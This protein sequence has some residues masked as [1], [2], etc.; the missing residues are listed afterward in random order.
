MLAPAW[1]KEMVVYNHWTGTSEPEWWTGIVEL[2]I[3]SFGGQRADM[4]NLIPLYMA[5]EGPQTAP[6]CRF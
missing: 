2:P 5:L 6:A 4:Q 1:V 3:C